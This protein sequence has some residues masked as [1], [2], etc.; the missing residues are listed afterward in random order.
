[1]HVYQES[2]KGLWT[3]GYYK[4]NGEWVALKDFGIE[5]LAAEWV[6]YLNGGK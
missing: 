6:N 1:M 3:V 2:E 4:P 5:Q